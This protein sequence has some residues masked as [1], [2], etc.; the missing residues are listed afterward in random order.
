MAASYLSSELRFASYV[1]F[2][3]HLRSVMTALLSLGWNVQQSAIVRF[4]LRP[5][6]VEQ[7][8]HR[9]LP[10]HRRCLNFKRKLWTELFALLSC[11]LIVLLFCRHWCCVFIVHIFVLWPRSS[12]ELCISLMPFVLTLNFIHLHRH[13]VTKWSIRVDVTKQAN[14]LSLLMFLGVNHMYLMYVSL[15]VCVAILDTVCQFV[16]IQSATK[17][18]LWRIILA[19]DIFAKLETVR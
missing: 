12:S 19:N 6:A 1:I 9:L 16:Q 18:A 11:H 17:G 14:K 7:S 15:M 13:P 8:C 2:R 4:Q 3:R 5:H 10:S